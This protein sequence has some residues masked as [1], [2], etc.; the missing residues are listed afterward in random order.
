MIHVFAQ[1]L[2]LKVLL[3]STITRTCYSACFQTLSILVKQAAYSVYQQRVIKAFTP[4]GNLEIILFA[5]AMHAKRIP[6]HQT[7]SVNSGES[8]AHIG[9]CSL[10]MLWQPQQQHHH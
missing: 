7:C 10:V 1:T 4:M 5:S 2:C 8:G 3:K 9:V 6:I